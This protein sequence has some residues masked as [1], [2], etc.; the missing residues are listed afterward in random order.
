VSPCGVAN[1]LPVVLLAMSVAHGG[2][3]DIPLDFHLTVGFAT[4][5]IAA[6]RGDILSWTTDVAANGHAVQRVIYNLPHHPIRQRAATFS[7]RE[8]ATLVD[9]IKRRRFFSL[10]SDLTQCEDCGMFSLKVTMA[11]RTHEVLLSGAGMVKDKLL[12][13]RFYDVWAPAVRKV[14]SPFGNNGEMRSLR[15]SI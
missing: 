1:W 10:P 15:E 4:Q 14:P 13:R 11:G 5:N 3:T 2:A 6:Q 9:A 7:E 12:V 8:V